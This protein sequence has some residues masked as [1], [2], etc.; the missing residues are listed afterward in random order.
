MNKI[1][2]IYYINLKKR[3]NRREHFLN[4]CIEHNIPLVK[5]ERFEAIDGLLF[6]FPENI[7][8]MFQNC[9]FF[10][11]LKSY[12]EDGIDE[13]SYKNA[14]DITKKLMGNQISHYSILNDIVDKEYEFSIIFQDDAK[15][16]NG[17]VDYIDNLLENVPDN[18][19]IINIGMNKYANC[20]D[21]IS[22]DFE[23]DNCTDI[24]KEYVNEYICK[25]TKD[26]NPC[27]LAYIVTRKGAKNLINHFLTVGFLKAT[28]CNYNEYL[29]FKDIF[30]SSER[31]VVT[32]ENFGSDIF[33][34]L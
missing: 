20:S 26:A 15:F 12:R 5:V 27:S 22:W 21:L 6:D 23:K 9:D 24:S 14:E 34:E 28:D 10:R 17:I 33:Q 2:R 13:K 1:N 4:Q 18:A 16:A 8:S 31:I 3:E 25:L 7:K 19:E 32:S 29:L 11:T 30:Y